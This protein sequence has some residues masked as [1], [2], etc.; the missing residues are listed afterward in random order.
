ML[1]NLYTDKVIDILYFFAYY[2]Y[3]YQKVLYVDS[4]IHAILTFVVSIMYLLEIPFIQY[5]YLKT[6]L[7]SVFYCVLD[8]K[9]FIFNKS[10][11]YRSILFLHFIII[12]VTILVNTIFNDSYIAKHLF[13]INYL[14]EISTPIL[15]KIL[16]LKNTSFKKKYVIYKNLLFLTFFLSRVLG[17]MYFLYIS[18]FST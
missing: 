8:I 11:G 3:I 18:I 10:K 13:A 5:Y 1:L 2:R 15:N 9:K 7:L 14:T 4:N 17:G 12:V 16:Q 6:M